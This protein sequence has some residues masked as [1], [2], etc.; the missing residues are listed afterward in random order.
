M[1]GLDWNASSASILVS[2]CSAMDSNDEFP[3]WRRSERRRTSTCQA[4][5]SPAFAHRSVQE[6]TAAT[7]NRSTS[8]TADRTANV[9][10][11]LNVRMLNSQSTNTNAGRPIPAKATMPLRESENSNPAPPM[12][13]VRCESAS[14][15][16]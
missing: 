13:M 7:P 3:D 9:A 15:R 4:S 10:T 11:R 12:A 2:M 16:R 5:G 14:R 1:I 8:P 6:T